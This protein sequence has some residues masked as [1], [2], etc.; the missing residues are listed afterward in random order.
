MPVHVLII[1]L[2]GYA[3][4]ITETVHTTAFAVEGTALR[5]GVDYLAS[6]FFRTGI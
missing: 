3:E 4:V 1:T 5:Q 2:S 6:E